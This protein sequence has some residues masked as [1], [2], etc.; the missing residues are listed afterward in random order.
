MAK[1][2]DT[3]PTSDHN[4]STIPA[5]GFQVVCPGYDSTIRDARIGDIPQRGTVALHVKALM[6]C[7]DTGKDDFDF[8]PLD[9]GMRVVD[10]S[11]DDMEFDAH[12]WVV[13][14]ADGDER[15][16]FVEVTMTVFGAICAAPMV[17]R[18]VDAEF[19]DPHDDATIDI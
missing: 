15:K 3:P 2:Q 4:P 7:P 18:A 14:R 13:S 1:R 5:Y 19:G 17:Q 8:N 12:D 16:S 10:A 9:S 11:G 6:F